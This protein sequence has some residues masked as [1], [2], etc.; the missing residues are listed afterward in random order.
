MSN[1]RG[2]KDANERER[3]MNYIAS[4]G[5]VTLEEVLEGILRE[6]VDELLLT[7]IRI[8]LEQAIIENRSI[9][10]QQLLE[11]YLEWQEGQA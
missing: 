2:P 3:L 5:G 11:Q 1:V 7:A 8:S 9:D 10:I 4:G 6:S